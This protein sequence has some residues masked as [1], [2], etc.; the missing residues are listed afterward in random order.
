MVI[1]NSI[2]KFVYGFSGG[3]GYQRWDF[4]FIFQGLQDVDTYLSGNLAQ[5]FKNGA[6]V[7]KNW[8]TDSWTSTNTGASLP[9]LTTS[10]GYPQNFQTSSFWVRDASYLRL[11]N[12]QVSYSFPSKWLSKAG[13]DVLKVF[14]NAQNYLTFSN[15][16]FSDPERNLTRADLIEYPNAKTIS[17]GLNVS[18]K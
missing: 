10:N 9:R 7:T 3:F 12:V 4:S 18:F 2:P 8:L 6:G 17:A 13:I 14:V 1:G 16:K 15:F 5:P 11:K